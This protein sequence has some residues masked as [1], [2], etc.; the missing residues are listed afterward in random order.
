MKRFGQLRFRLALCSFA[1][2]SLLISG[3]SRPP[4][5]AKEAAK[6]RA[7][8]APEP[9]KEAPPAEAPK[10]PEPKAETKKEAP[11]AT[12]KAEAPKA[13]APKVAKK[14]LAKPALFTEQAPEE[15]TVKFDTS[16][17]PFVVAVH[18]SWAPRGAD[19][20][21]NLVKYG[22][23]EQNRFF[24]I[25]PNFIVQFGLPA[26]PKVSMAWRNANI[27]DDAVMKSNKRGYLT[28]ATAGP[29]TR[30]TQLFIN[31]KDNAFLD[32]QGFA[33]FG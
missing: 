11:P 16:N 1:A 26:E 9:A 33:P 30:T 6:E 29:N 31:L 3:C 10:P 20:F 5:P 17:G 23:F 24:R 32:G 19:R 7:E 22:F 4:E 18:R 15:F 13:E 12:K 14:D 28:F 25:V 21:Y 2:L 8:S 27:K